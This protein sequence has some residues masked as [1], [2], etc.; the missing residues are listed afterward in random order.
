M[1]SGNGSDTTDPVRVAVLDLGTNTFNLLIGELDPG[2]IDPRTLFADRFPVKLGKEGMNEGLISQ[3][4]QQRG[5]EAI[6]A[7]LESCEE[8]GVQERIALATSGIRS[9]RN[10]DAFLRMLEER[11][12][13]TP[14]VIDGDREADLIGEGVR[15]AAPIGDD[16]VLV[17]DIGGGSSEFLILDRERTYWKRSFDIGAA[18]MLSEIDP[19]DP[20]EAEEIDR[21]R[22]GILGTIHPLREALRE[23]PVKTLIGCSGSFESMSD[24]AFH[25]FPDAA[26]PRGKA[27]V[28]LSCEH[29]RRLHGSLLGST[30]EERKGMKGLAEMR[31]EM[32]VLGSVMIE[33]VMD[34]A[35]IERL[36]T[37]YF[38]LREGALREF[39]RL[40]NERS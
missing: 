36:F 17:L 30:L 7:H 9:A 38:A 8:W 22:H 37:S 3:E 18:R 20:I 12:G 1:T 2:G 21:A 29:F 25:R 10:G 39:A 13:L 27:S 35:G 23:H 26:D 40:R 15:A 24:M 16:P 33:T 5:I 19:S 34:L 14:E 6:N 11:T 28:E 32:I 31:A 4:A